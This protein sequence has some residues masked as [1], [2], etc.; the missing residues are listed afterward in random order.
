MESNIILFTKQKYTRKEVRPMKKIISF[1]LVAFLLIGTAP[2]LGQHANASETSKSNMIKMLTE[3]RTYA[4]KYEKKYK[5][6]K[7]FYMIANGGYELYCPSKNKT[8][9]SRKAFLDAMDGVL[10]ED[11]YYGWDC[12]VNNATPTKTTKVM[13][14]ALTNAKNYYSHSNS[15]AIFNMEYCK[16]TKA[17]TAAKK[18]KNLGSVWFCAPRVDLDKVASLDS[19]RVNKNNITKP[20]DVKNFMALLDDEYYANKKHYSKKKYLNLIADTN[21]D[22]IFIDMYYDGDLLT[23]DDVNKLRKKKNGK[24]RLVCTYI[25]VGEAEDYRYYWKKEWKK[26]ANRPAWIVKEN[27]D[28]KGN[29]KVKYWY[30]G[31]KNILYKGS[32]SYLEKAISLGFDGAYI[33]VIDAY[34]EF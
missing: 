13:E 31:W 2:L 9:S 26:K 14:E 15:K 19:S 34:E 33:D 6:N 21:Y 29:F 28:W 4:A 17:K 3:M 30:D 16:D 32:N 11:I 20:K 22:M 10:I 23:K 12:E 24:K 5:N 25:S 8:K 27:K 7:T 1:A 18:S